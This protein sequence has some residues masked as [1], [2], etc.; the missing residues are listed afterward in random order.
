MSGRYDEAL[1]TAKQLLEHSK[2][3][4]VSPLIA[5]RY[6]APIYIRLGMEDKARAHAEEILKID[7][8]F[9]LESVSSFMVFKDPAHTEKILGDLHKAG[10]PEHPHK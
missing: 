3:G 5:H 6:L 7:P 8:N 1:S 9:S 2:K 4:E 10:I